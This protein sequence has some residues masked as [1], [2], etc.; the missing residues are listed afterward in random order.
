MADKVFS[1]RDGIVAKTVVNG[2]PV[3]PEEVAW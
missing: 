2:N 3:P 1:I